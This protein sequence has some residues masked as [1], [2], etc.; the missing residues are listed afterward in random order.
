MQLL[1]VSLQQDRGTHKDG[2][3][4]LESL[5]TMKSPDILPR[6]LVIA[7]LLL[8]P[9]AVP[10]MAERFDARPPDER[11]SVITRYNYRVRI[12]GRYLGHADREIRETYE[13]VS[14]S[15]R[16]ERISGWAR[17]LGSTKRN[18][19]PVAARLE[20]SRSVSFL[21]ADSG[22]VSAA[23]GP[24][25]SLQGFPAFPD[26]EIQPGDRW[27]APIGIGIIG[28]EGEGGVLPSIASYTYTGPAPYQGRSAHYFEAAWALR[29]QGYPG[30]QDPL[31][32]IIE[33]VSGSH[34]VTLVMDA[35]SGAPLMARNSL[36]EQWTWADSRVEEREGFALIF[37][38]GVPPLDVNAVAKRF[39][40]S[41]AA[42][43]PAWGIPPE[44]SAALPPAGSSPPAPERPF[45]PRSPASEPP[46]S[47][48]LSASPPPADTDTLTIVPTPAGLSVTL[49]NLHFKADTALILPEDRPLLDEIAA[50]LADIPHRTVVVRGHT[51]EVGRPAE[52]DALSEERA[53]T[54]ADELSARGTAPGRLIY[55]GVGAA[56][57]LAPNDTEEGRRRNRRVELLIIED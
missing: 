15:P 55:E 48:P 54:V 40:R 43:P 11:W 23:L 57:P 24:F 20:S 4:G 16:G 8:T 49:H 9:C 13:R 34:R 42:A 46:A 30:T 36:R 22:S 37:W 45:A 53:K 10:L 50:V 32:R 18:G 28:P 14:R 1:F 6:I 7:A 39:G 41:P 38:R 56:E 5:F 51:A 29:Y 12:N 2:V 31:G 19:L 17:V 26:G 52:Q 25:P 3:S 33:A 44:E 21:L 35:E 47:D 27:E